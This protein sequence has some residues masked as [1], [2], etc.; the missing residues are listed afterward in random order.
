VLDFLKTIF[1]PQPPSGATAKERLRLVL[2]SD[3]LSLAPEVVDA[4]KSELIEV[5]S[6]Y[7]EI[8]RDHTD[9]TFEHRDREIAMLASIP[10]TG[11]HDRPRPSAPPP[12]PPPNGHPHVPASDLL[13]DEPLPSDEPQTLPPA[14]FEPERPAAI[15]EVQPRLELVAAPP[16]PQA[17]PMFRPAQ[18]ANGRPPRRRRRKKGKRPAA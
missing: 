5:I 2:L 8:D 17:P 15:E 13:S 6:R 16:K 12:P 10:I 11:M 14:A 4:L 3:H 1:R 9:V 7:V 18:S